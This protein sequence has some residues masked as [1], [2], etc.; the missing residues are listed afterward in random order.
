MIQRQGLGVVGGRQ[1]AI[2]D[3]AHEDI[4]MFSFPCA[5]RYILQHVEVLGSVRMQKQTDVQTD[6]GQ[7]DVFVSTTETRVRNCSSNAP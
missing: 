1:A 3:W 5:R 6:K 7:K 2:V 4:S